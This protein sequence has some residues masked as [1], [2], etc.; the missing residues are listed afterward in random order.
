MGLEEQIGLDVGVVVPCVRELQGYTGGELS[1]E[2]VL[3]V[4]NGEVLVLSS[5][6]E[7][8]NETLQF[9]F[10]VERHTEEFWRGRE[11]GGREG[12]ESE[13]GR[14][15]GGREEECKWW[16]RRVRGT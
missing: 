15:A 8:F 12:R 9:C 10:V 16:E 2:G 7:D 5:R 1:Q 3:L 4:P 13:R 14:K 11:G 6:G